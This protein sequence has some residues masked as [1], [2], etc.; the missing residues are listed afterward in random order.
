[1][2]ETT[3]PDPVAQPTATAQPT[4]ARRAPGLIRGVLG[5]PLFR[6]AYALLLNSGAGALFGVGFWAVATRLYDA[7][8]VGVGMALLSAMRMLT[9]ITS[10]GFVGFLTRFVPEAG[11]R[12]RRL[13]LVV[14]LAAGA[15]SAVATAVF[16]LGL[17]LWG[18]SFHILGDLPAGLLFGCMVLVWS[19]WSLQDVVL[20]ALRKATWVPLESLL[21]GLVKL[22]VLVACVALV[23]RTGEIVS[24]V[25]FLSWIGPGVVAVTVVNAIIFL[26]LTRAP[27]DGAADRMLPGRRA[28][29]RFL[30]G[31]YL[32]SLCMLAFLYIVPV[33]VAAQVSKEVNAYYGIA[34]TLG[35]LLETFAYTMATSLTVEGAFDASTLAGNTRRAVRRTAVTLVPIVGA[36]ILAAPYILRIF[37]ADYAAHATPLLQLLAVA[38]LPRALIELYLG[39]LRAYGRPRLIVKIQA[40]MAGLAFA[41]VLGLLPVMGITG[42]GLGLLAAQTVVA[43]AAVPGLLRIVRSAQP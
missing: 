42:V 40:L 39:A 2:S 18:P 19:L 35:A 32:G 34:V 28:M 16:L 27:A 9:A 10:L 17:P 29:G 24:W 11:G 30:V 15:L 43:A 21:F 33:I 25:V 37:G 3:I 1:M 7:A 31:D 36:T 14:Y 13:I 38:T 4:A 5:D 12:A 22:L 8:D 23:P 20:T 6:N 41:G 26:R